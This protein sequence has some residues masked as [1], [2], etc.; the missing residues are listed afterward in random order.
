[1]NKE[2][3]LILAKAFIADQDAWKEMTEA[4]SRIA[5]KANTDFDFRD[6]P[7]NAEQLT[8]GVVSVLGEEFSYW[9]YDSG[10]DF[11]KFNKG[12][13]MPDGTHPNVHNLDELYE[14]GKNE[15]AGLVL[16]G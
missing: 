6:L 9:Y 10:K 3:W 15:E 14:F 12:I 16:C 11:E 13:T 7:Y 4:L 2:S 5:R 8:G 1:M